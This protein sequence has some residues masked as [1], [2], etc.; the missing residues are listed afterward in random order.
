MKK[1]SIRNLFSK[2]FTLVE[3]LVVIA[4]LAILSGAAYIGVQKSQARL[5]N[6]K[7]IDDLAA[8]SNALEQ[9]RQDYGH[10]PNL[11]DDPAIILGEDKNVNCFYADTT[12]AHDCAAAAFV[13]TMVDN[14][15]LT[16][17]YLQEIPTDPRTGSRYVYGVTTDG[18]YFQVSGVYLDSEGSLSARVTGNVEQ[19][20]EL[21]SLIRAYNGPNFVMNGEGY[22]PYN[23]DHLNIT[24]TLN[25]INGVNVTVD[26]QAAGNGMVIRPG[27]M[28]ETGD[29]STVVIYFSDGSITYL[30]VNTKLRFL[31]N[32]NVEQ[33]DEDG[34]IT[35]IRLKL[36]S[37]E[38]WNKVAR[39]AEE[40]E[41]DV[42]TTS[43]IAG[44]RG[45]EWGIDA[46]DNITVLSGQ[47]AARKKTADE[48]QG[49]EGE[50]EY[51]EEISK[52]ESFPDTQVTP[53]SYTGTDFVQFEIPEVG[54]AIGNGTTVV[55]TG[56]IEALQTDYYTPPVTNNVRPKILKI[57]VTNGIAEFELPAIEP[58]E[59]IVVTEDDRIMG[60]WSNF[61]VDSSLNIITVN[62]TNPGNTTYSEISSHLDEGE[63]VWFKYVFRSV[64]NEEVYSQRTLVGITIEDET[65]LTDEEIYTPPVMAGTGD[66]ENT[67]TTG[68]DSITLSVD[69]EQAYYAL[70]AS[71][72]LKL[73]ESPSSSIGINLDGASLGNFAA[74][75]NELTVTL[76]DTAGTYSIATGDPKIAPITL[77]VCEYV[78]TDG[79]E[80]WVMG[81]PGQSCGNG[82]DGAC[83]AIILDCVEGDWDVTNTEN[84]AVCSN[85][86]DGFAIS[87]DLMMQT[88]APYATS[89]CKPR[90]DT[91][92]TGA[93]N[94][95]C[96][97]EGLLAG[98]APVSRI[99]KCE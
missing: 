33:N 99:C 7:M 69:G 24:A 96:E 45:T 60:T 55:D 54:T 21:P 1:A 47:V 58:S 79:D 5:M 31:P 52:T 14:K 23:P 51:V 6:E 64:A 41:F 75:Q 82:T 29:G 87:T 92:Y 56:V 77:S 10:Y 30:Q 81:S 90:G 49:S 70:G 8:I 18:N 84:T 62:T 26:G 34:I 19:G 89:E 93:P 20:Y 53:E 3:L 57:D 27:Q 35:K 11:N 43:A 80:C 12:Y 2:G 9:F 48:M 65:L 40:S 78:G 85:L 97:A 44:V 68:T 59:I 72:I 61:A 39:L 17:R 46:D 98:V 86:T 37:G 71:V 95:D 88:Y 42:E 66:E 76:P 22:L 25:Q 36:F 13:Q 38:I 28:I 74:A 83:D 63:K 15:L 50:D 32:S 4:I 16:K 73:S 67:T 94:Q 91:G